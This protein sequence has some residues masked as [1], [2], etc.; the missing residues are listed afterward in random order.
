MNC[1]LEGHLHWPDIADISKEYGWKV[2]LYFYLTGEFFRNTKFKKYRYHTEV[3]FLLIL[4]KS[5]Y[6][7]TFPTESTKNLGQLML[8]T[9]LTALRMKVNFC[10]SLWWKDQIH[11]M[12]VWSKQR[13]PNFMPCLIK[14]TSNTLLNLSPSVIFIK[15][16]IFIPT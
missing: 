8:G 11:I 5:F 12:E 16:I 13:K 2:K 15:V 7:I 10:I 9:V 3:K 4:V 14:Q 1:S 6:K